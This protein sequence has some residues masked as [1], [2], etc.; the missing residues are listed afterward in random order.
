MSFLSI[1][2]GAPSARHIGYVI[3]IYLGAG[4]TG[5]VAAAANAPLPWMIGAILFAMTV[6]LTHGPVRVP[7][8]TRPMGQIIVAGSV[9]LSF[10]PAAVQALGNMLWA[11]VAAALLT[12]GAGLLVARVLMRLGGTDAIT[13][14]L[15]SVPMGPVESVNLANRY[16]VAPG[17][18]VFSQTVRIMAIILMIPPVL[19]A[20][21]PEVTD[22][23][24]ALRSMPWTV[25]GGAL[26][27][28][29]SLVGFAVI[30]RLRLSNPFFLGSL[31]GAALA[32]ALALPISAYPYPVLA[33]AQILLGVWL[34]AVFDRAF[35]REAGR[36]VPAALLSTLLMILLCLGLG[37][38]L[39]PLTGSHWTTMILGTAPGSVT[40][41]A[42]TAKLLHEGIAVV[43]AFHVI[44][45]FII[46]PSAPLII[47][48]VARLT[49]WHD[50]R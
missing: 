14:S 13:A 25:H 38:A 9:G 21:D 32:S 19:I 37:L 41:M 10:T 43:T 8:I 2:N 18:V 39:A 26:L 40:E 15:S 36:F 20:L 27:L 29:S 34:G 16:G 1:G 48:M 24:A 3:L 17:P 44:R 30:R 23:S 7:V 11:M 42:L 35:F 22:P 49:H 33:G 47:R 28:A 45:I 46:M 5:W 31:A 4:A 6:S 12:I 50:A